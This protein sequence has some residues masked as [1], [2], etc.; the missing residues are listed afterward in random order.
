[1]VVSTAP[2]T[3]VGFTK[4]LPE[5]G[6]NRRKRVYPHT[7]SHHLVLFLPN[8]RD[9]RFVPVV[10]RRSHIL[11]VVAD[12][13]RLRLVEPSVKPVD[14]RLVG[15]PGDVYL[16]SSVEQITFLWPRYPVISAYSRE[17]GPYSRQRGG[18]WWTPAGPIGPGASRTSSSSG[19]FT[20]LVHHPGRTSGEEE[21]TTPTALISGS[22]FGG[23]R[24]AAPR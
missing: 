1:M 3:T 10:R 18:R 15:T 2:L 7:W 11:M 19:Q 21:G 5:G 4:V 8:E 16:P 24:S 9:T 22:G 12:F 23:S 20:K 6:D 17:K 14:R 13:L